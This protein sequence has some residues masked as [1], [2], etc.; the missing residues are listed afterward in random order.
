[1]T[2][3]STI[4]TAIGPPEPLVAMTLPP[5]PPPQVTTGIFAASAAAM[6]APIELTGKT[7][8]TIALAPRWTKILDAGIGLVGGALRIDHRTSQPRSAAAFS[9][10]LM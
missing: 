4:G 8:S 10:P 1:M 5:R 2:I 3:I 9:A 7:M 6:P